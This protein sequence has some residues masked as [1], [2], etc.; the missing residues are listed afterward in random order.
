MLAIL[1][2]IYFAVAVIKYPSGPG[3]LVADLIHPQDRAGFQFLAIAVLITASLLRLRLIRSI[4]RNRTSEPKTVPVAPPPVA[5]LPASLPRASWSQRFRALLIDVL[6][7]Y[8]LLVP[9]ALI[10]GAIDSATGNTTTL[11]VLYA[12]SPILACAFI[13]VSLRR[14]GPG[15]ATPGKRAMKIRLVEADGSTPTFKRLVLREFV[16]KWLV[17]SPFMVGAI[18]PLVNYLRPLWNDSRSTFY[19]DW[20][21]MRVVQLAPE[22]A[23]ESVAVAVA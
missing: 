1:V 20:L 23:P 8:G 22:E 18:Y 14:G 9:L 12:L 2:G 5:L 15:F 17:F 4:R 10:G 21:K 11:I 19:D 6:A 13:R 16:L 7:F 3:F